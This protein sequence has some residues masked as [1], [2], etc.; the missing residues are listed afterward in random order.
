MILNFAEIKSELARMLSVNESAS[1]GSWAIR[2][3]QT[4]RQR[5]QLMLLTL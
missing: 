2:F 5:Q 4:Q 1:S 3:R